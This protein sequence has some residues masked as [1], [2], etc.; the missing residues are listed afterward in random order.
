MRPG[1]VASLSLSESYSFEKRRV[2]QV[3]LKEGLGVDGDIHCGQTVR[4]RS[5]IATDPTQPNLRQVHLIPMELL[6]ELMAA[7]YDVWP[8]RL[9][10]NVTTEGLDLL[11]L[12]AGTRLTLGEDAIVELTGLRNPCPQLNDVGPDL[13]RRL[14]SR[15]EAGELIR[16]AGVMA[17]VRAGGL[18]RAGDEIRVA[19]P[20]E[21]HVPMDRV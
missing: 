10:E 20:P 17:I 6:R 21:P 14:A 12:P 13:M 9:G 1:R 11:A 7:G 4:H 2:A 5:R 8:G 18:V 3:R 15:N 19:L 16:R